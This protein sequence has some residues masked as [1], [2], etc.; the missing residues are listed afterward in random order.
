MIDPRDGLECEHCGGCAIKADFAG[1][2]EQSSGGRCAE[3]GCPGWVSSD[4]AG[5]VVWVT[6]EPETERAL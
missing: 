1:A 4:Y 6:D 2:Y 5:A 3:C